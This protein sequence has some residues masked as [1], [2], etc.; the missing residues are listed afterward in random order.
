MLTAL[1]LWLYGWWVER[2][3]K[4]EARHTA[5]R[6]MCVIAHA[7]YSGS[8]AAYTLTPDLPRQENSTHIQWG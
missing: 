8:T 2:R 3:R 7:V 6:H 4:T 1:S 5:L